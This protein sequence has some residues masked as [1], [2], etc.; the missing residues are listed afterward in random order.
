MYVNTRNTTS[1]LNITAVLVMRDLRQHHRTFIQLCLAIASMY[2]LIT[3]NKRSVSKYSKHI[4]GCVLCKSRTQSAKRWI[5]CIMCVCFWAWC[6]SSYQGTLWWQHGAFRHRLRHR[7][8]GVSTQSLHH[9]PRLE[10]REPA[11]FWQRLRQAGE[12]MSEWMRCTYRTC[13]AETAWWFMTVAWVKRAP[14]SCNC[15]L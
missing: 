7:G 5:S 8:A 4:V 10:A 6:V 13:I 15:W 2:S 11:A 14:A 1:W 3:N 9:L 12:W